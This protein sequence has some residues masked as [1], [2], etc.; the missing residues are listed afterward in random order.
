MRVTCSAVSLDQLEPKG[1]V[2]KNFHTNM[3]AVFVNTKTHF[4]PKQI[5]VYHVHETTL[6]AL[7]GLRYLPCGL[8]RKLNLKPKT[9]RQAHSFGKWEICR[10][11]SHS[12]PPP[13]RA[14]GV[15]ARAELLSQAPNFSWTHYL[16]FSAPSNSDTVSLG[17]TSE[18]LLWLGTLSIHKGA[19]K[20]SST[21]KMRLI[22]SSLSL[23]ADQVLRKEPRTASLSCQ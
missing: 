2:D 11:T 21:W 15:H 1:H 4:G 8:V 12:R 22:M 7:L 19:S 13:F 10:D 18:G 9:R 17:S 5:K 3:A 23:F 14:L 6:I 20:F 16:T